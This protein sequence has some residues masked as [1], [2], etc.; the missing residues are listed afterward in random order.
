MLLEGGMV[1][2]GRGAAAMPGTIGD[3]RVSDTRDDRIYPVTRGIIGAIIPFLLV[4]FA[5]LYFWPDD[6]GRLFA[7]TIRPRMTPLLMGA[8]Y[9]AG[10]YFFLRL[11][12][13]ARWHHVGIG[14]LPVT[15][16]AS[17]MLLATLLHWDRFN[18]DH[19]S[20]YAWIILYL[21]T[22]AIVLALWIYNRRADPGTPDADDVAIPLPVR[23]VMGAAGAVVFGTG[24]LLFLFP[25]TMIAI[26]PWSLTPLTAR[27]AGGWFALPGVFGLAIAADRRWSAARFALQSQ[28]LGIALILIGVARAW[29][30]FDQSR[31][32]TWGFVAG[33]VGL[34]IAIAALYIAM[35]ARRV[36]RN[37]ATS[38]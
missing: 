20:F 13:A 11:L 31:P 35:E 30:D 7:W 27:V 37:G 18:H 10:A 38:R 26:W 9:I 5:M 8:G 2:E 24:V 23:W 36:S 17:A 1:E 21:T 16:F 3:L 33:M 4:A 34:L 19:V 28:A 22:P 25:N 32:L 15:A 12:W 29:G 14:F 6:T